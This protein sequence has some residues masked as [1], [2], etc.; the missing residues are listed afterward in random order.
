MKNIT[1][2]SKADFFTNH[3]ASFGKFDVNIES[4]LRMKVNKA[5]SV[6]ILGNLVYD[7]DILFDIVDADGEP[8]GRKGPRTQFSESINVGITHS[9]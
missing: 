5:I 1:L 3:L 7:E 8:S 4:Q 2:Q 9:F 6:N